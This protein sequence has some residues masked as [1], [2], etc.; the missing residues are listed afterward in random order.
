MSSFGKI[1]ITGA[2]AESFLLKTCAGYMGRSPGAVI[3]SAVLNDRGTYETD[4]IAQR[5]TEN[6]YRLFVGT[7]TIKRDLA[8][9]NNAAGDFNVSIEDSTEKF[10]VL[11][12]AG[13]R[14]AQIVTECGAPELNEL[15]YFK[16]A[17]ACIA[18]RCVRAARISYVGEAGW[19]ITC[20]TENLST[21]YAALTAAG[22][23]PAG[24]F[25]QAS[26]RI[27]KGFCA[28]G[29]ELDNDLGPI[30]VGLDF[31]ARKAGGFIGFEAMEKQRGLGAT[32]HLMSLIFDDVNAVPLGHEP[33]YLNKVIIGQTTSCAFGYRVGKPVALGYLK[34]LVENSTKITVNIAGK[35]HSATAIIGSLFD[36][37]GLLMKS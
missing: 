21:V 8:W 18:G 25:A 13:P 22:A 20:L 27:E 4:I 2:K 36:P 12:L 19:E 6:H 29:H 7:N 1:E 11:S 23:R 35:L 26:M 9:F 15:G 33:I 31:A 28:M 16:S 37:N 30:E 10:G 24:L 32:N 34:K 5:I 3:Y 17:A 14:A